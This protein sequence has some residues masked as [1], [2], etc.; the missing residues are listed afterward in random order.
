MPRQQESSASTMEG[1]LW[2]RARQRVCLFASHLGP[3]S[4]RACTGGMLM[5]PPAS[6][7]SSVG[8]PP[9][10]W[11]PPTVSLSELVARNSVGSCFGFQ[12]LSSLD[13]CHITHQ[14]WKGVTEIFL[15]Q[16]SPLTCRE[17]EAQRRTVT[18]L[19]TH[20]GYGCLSL[21]RH[22]NRICRLSSFSN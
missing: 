19:E 13:N 14:S 21:L 1:D 3:P 10:L 5:L 11:A 12:T 20:C 8:Q 2:L 22:H 7:F 17:T 16:Y 4:S 18:C 15:V 9:A 6:S